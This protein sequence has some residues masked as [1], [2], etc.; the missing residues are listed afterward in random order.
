MCLFLLF[1]YGSYAKVVSVSW[2][3]TEPAAPPLARHV[4]AGFG[5]FNAAAFVPE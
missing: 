2:L 3:Q 5:V 1:F 4:Q